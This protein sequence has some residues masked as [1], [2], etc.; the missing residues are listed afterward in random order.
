MRACLAN[1][2]V[3]LFKTL[4]SEFQ[5]EINILFLESLTG[6]KLIRI[7]LQKPRSRSSCLVKQ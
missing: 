3:V 5:E 7:G 4:T 6:F 1:I 2:K